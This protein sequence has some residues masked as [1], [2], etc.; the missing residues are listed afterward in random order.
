MKPWIFFAAGLLCLAALAFSLEPGQPPAALDNFFPPKAPAP[1]L[2]FKMLE[3]NEALAG[4]AVNMMEQDFENAG[5]HYATFKERY[6]AMSKLVPEWERYYDLEAV[7][8]LGAAMKAGDQGRVMAAFGRVGGTCHACHVDNMAAVQFKYHWDDFSRVQATDPVT[9]QPSAFAPFMQHMAM[10]FDGIGIDLKE[11]QADRAAKHAEDFE[12]RFHAMGETCSAC[13]QTE[14]KYYV[15][16]S[17]TAMVSELTAVA[18]SP[19]PDLAKLGQLTQ[20]IGM[21]SCFKC[22]LVHIPA[23]TA[24]ARWKG[25]PA[26][27]HHNE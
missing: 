13:H 1:V 17:V 24:H 8:E 18:K 16:A 6:A 12:K 7:D 10:S 5:K 20:A 4:T 27:A 15:D 9:N 14:R 21:E 23:A 3:L 26:S 25:A 19:N 2:L 22:H 11:G